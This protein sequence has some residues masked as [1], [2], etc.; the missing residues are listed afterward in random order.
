MKHE[1]QNH[2]LTGETCSCGRDHSEHNKFHDRLD[3]Q[4]PCV[5]GHNHDD[6]KDH[7]HHDHQHPKLG[8]DDVSITHHE[9]AVIVSAE[10]E[11]SGD[12]TQVKETLAL[13]LKDLADW[14]DSQNGLVGH[15]KAHLST[16]GNS[17]MISTTGD[18]VQIKETDSTSVSINLA[19]IVFIENETGLADQVTQLLKKTEQK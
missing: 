9:N 5:C 17:A 12:F 16:K 2:Q 11:I 8:H 7:E 10:R 18:A 3:D 19:V 6:Y 4:E 14:V 15:I 1:H 13:G